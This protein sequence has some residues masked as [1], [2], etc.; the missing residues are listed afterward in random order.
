M[1]WDTPAPTL[2]QNF[3]FVSSDKKIHP[4]QNRVLSI[5]EGLRLQ[6]ISNYDYKF[7][8]EGKQISMAR[9]CEIIGESVPPKLVE[10]ICKNII[11]IE[12]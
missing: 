6:S 1:S 11:R 12:N 8:I 10:L 9:C 4:D 5:F 2:T 7:S 3:Q